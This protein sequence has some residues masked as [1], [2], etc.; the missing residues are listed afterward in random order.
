MCC[1]VFRDSNEKQALFIEAHENSRRVSLTLAGA[2]R[3]RMHLSDSD[4]ELFGAVRSAGPTKVRN[5]TMLTT[6]RDDLFLASQC[7][8]SDCGLWLQ[9]SII[10][11]ETQRIKQGVT[12]YTVFF[13]RT[14]VQ[15]TCA[16]VVSFRRTWNVFWI[17]SWVLTLPFAIFHIWCHIQ[18]LYAC[19]PPRQLHS[20]GVSEKP[21]R[22][23][24]ACATVSFPT[25]A[26]NNL[27]HN[28]IDNWQGAV[29]RGQYNHFCTQ[30][31]AV[32]ETI[33]TQNVHTLIWQLEFPTVIKM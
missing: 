5:F 26:V 28:R 18:V 17:A 19:I 6:T 3:F 21:L 32:S 27:S 25:E 22:N 2:S 15:R 33:T 16:N 4:R 7:L 24:V 13:L 29:V 14:F 11:R 12:Q 1:N 23:E 10:L 30:N 9:R 8:S 20:T 31:V